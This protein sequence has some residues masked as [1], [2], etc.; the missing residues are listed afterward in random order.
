MMAAPI[1]QLVP[2]RRVDSGTAG[3]RLAGVGSG[4][5]NVDGVGRRADIPA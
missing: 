4:R 2:N 3:L 1:D 5:G